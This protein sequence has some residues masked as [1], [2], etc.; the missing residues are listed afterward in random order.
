MAS[1]SITSWQIEGGKADFIFFGFKITTHDGSSDESKTEKPRQSIKK[2]RHH[3]PGKG[4]FSQNY[5]FF[6]S[7]VLM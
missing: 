5:V 3:F 1:G 6:S 2:Q 7:Y 4:P